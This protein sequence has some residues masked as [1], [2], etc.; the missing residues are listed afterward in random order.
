MRHS[1][2]YKLARFLGKPISANRQKGIEAIAN[3]YRSIS[4]LPGGAIRFHYYDDGDGYWHV[5][6]T[7]IEG[8]ITGGS[9]NDNVEEMIEDAVYTYYGIPPEFCTQKMGFTIREGVRKGKNGK[10]SKRRIV[11]SEEILVAA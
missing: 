9:K 2:R 4:S 6:S 8:I 7:N 11:G 10:T 5:E 3:M 1:A